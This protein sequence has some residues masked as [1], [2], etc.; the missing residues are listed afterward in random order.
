MNHFLKPDASF[1]VMR[2]TIVVI[3]LFFMAS[4]VVRG[5]AT[6]TTTS[7]GPPP[8]PPPSDPVRPPPPP[9]PPNNPPP[10]R[11]GLPMPKWNSTGWTLLGET[12]VNG[13]AGVDRD[14]IK[15]GAGEGRYTKLTLVVADSDVELEGMDVVFLNKEKFSPPL[16]HHFREGTQTREIELPGNA[17]RII[18]MIELRY[19]NT[20]GGGPARVQVWGWKAMNAPPSDKG[21]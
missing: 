10:K 20:P 7:G 4:C 19:K 6:G 8:P 13:R 12:T 1:T 18:S 3:A 14:I 2:R 21:K 17:M 11:I 16:R 15:V 5:R 9:P